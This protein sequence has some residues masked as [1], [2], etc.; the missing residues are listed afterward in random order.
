MKLNLT[1]WLMGKGKLDVGFNF[2]LSAS[3]GAF[4]YNGKLHEMDGKVMNRITKPLGMV[5]INRAK[6]K[7]MA[8][9]IKADS[10]RSAGTMAFRFN[11]LSVAMLKKDTEKNKLVRQGLISF[12]ANNLI[13]YS[14]NPS[15]D[16]KFTRAVINY[17]RP[18]TASFFSFIWRSLFTGIKYSVGVTPAKESAIR[19]KIAQFEQMKVDRT[20][21]RET[22]EM[23]K[24][25]RN[26]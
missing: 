16:K 14:D 2:D 23:R 22:R 12:L 13:I 8:F 9:S 21:R 26:R 18:E 4:S 11:D 19:S 24:R 7:D 6:V 5:Q 15:A 25:M 20:Q 17:T 3:N 1:T 10:Y